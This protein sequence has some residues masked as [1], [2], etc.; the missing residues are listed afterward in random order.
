MELQADLHTHTIASG[1][2]FSTV[3]EMASA[4]AAAGLQL[5]GIADHGVNMPGAP[6]EYYFSQLLTLPDEIEGIHILKGVEA[7]IIDSNGNLDMP[8]E[9]LSRLDL[10][11]AGFHAGCGFPSG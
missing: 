2:A 10:V 7:N 8:V 9:I 4:A 11:L 1:H 6:H 5:L 3:K